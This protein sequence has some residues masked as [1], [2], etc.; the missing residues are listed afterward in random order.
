[1]GCQLSRALLRNQGQE[2]SARGVTEPPAPPP[3]DPRIPLTAKQKFNMVKSWKGI[4]RAMEATGVYM[5]LELFETNAE[6]IGLFTKFNKLRTRDEQAESLELAEHATVVMN[7]IDEGIKAMDNVDFF[8]DL[9]YQIGASHHK[10]PGFKKEYFWKIEHPFLEAVRLTLGDRYTDNMDNIYRITI[11]FLLETVVKGY[12]MAEKKEPNDNV[13]E[14]SD[15]VKKPID[16]VKEPNDNAKEP[17]N[18][19]ESRPYCSKATK[20]S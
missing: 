8:F 17:A 14:L 19:L 2:K 18:S 5:F 15:N 13:K 20:G 11:K 12:E 4:N 7:S 16:N 10:I 9:L 6:L 3:L 1:M